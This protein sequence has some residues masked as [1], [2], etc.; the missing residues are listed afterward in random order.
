MIITRKSS[1]TFAVLAIVA[2]AL[3]G[4]TGVRPP[5]LPRADPYTAQQIHVDSEQLRKDTA[6]GAPLVQRDENG[7][8]R[9]TLPIRSAINKTLY[10]DYWVT[11]FDRD[12]QVESKIGPVTK[13]LQANTPDSITF[14]SMSAQAA[15]FQVD[16]RYA[17]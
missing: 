11:F 3:A 15:D 16:V 1:V 10:V 9:V 6:V 13:T 2:A 12:G 7:L 17:R 14:N 4:C 5:K 8:L